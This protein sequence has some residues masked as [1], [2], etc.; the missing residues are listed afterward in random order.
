MPLSWRAK[1]PAEIE[2]VYGESG[3]IDTDH[4]W[5][6]GGDGGHDGCVGDLMEMKVPWY[7]LDIRNLLVRQCH[8]PCYPRGRPAV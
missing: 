4:D 7:N 5:D 2:A 3:G 8:S 6:S 1:T